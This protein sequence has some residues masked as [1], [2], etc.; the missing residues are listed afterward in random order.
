MGDCVICHRTDV[1]YSVEHVIPEALGGCYLRKQMVCVD[2]NSKLGRRVDAALI[3][4]GLSKMFRFVHG[5][6]G[7]AKKPPNPF[8]GEYR[9]R[10]D[11]GRRMKIRI[12]SG[13][14]LIPSLIPEVRR[15]ELPDGR[16]GVNISVD[17]TDER[18]LEPMVRTIANRLGASA[19]E[20]VANA[21][22]T[23]L[24]SDGGLAGQLALDLRDFKIGLLKIA[25]ECAVDRIPDYVESGDAQQIARI[26]REARF[27]EVE[28]YVNIGDGF[29]RGIMAPFSNFLGY[30]GVKHYLVLCGSVTGVRCFVHLHDLFSIGVTLSTESFGELFE[31]GVND[32]E[33][34]SFKVW[35][36]E[37]MQVSTGYCPLLHFETKRKAAEFR[38]AERAEDFAYESNDGRWKL[39]T[40]DG[41]YTGSDVG[42]VVRMLAPIRSEIVSGGLME[43][44]WLGEGVYL[45][46][47]GSGEIV[48]V[49][50]V[51]AEHVWQKL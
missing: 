32:V 13:G 29:D 16:V 33:G 19:E 43:E 46:L 4:H 12:G 51:R 22:K 41:R 47:S 28:R 50:A 48:R 17:S 36:V 1:R 11:P 40:R 9:L 44:F 21:K 45:R 8:A 26:L 7:K 35:R 2:C 15:D 14:R 34:R 39:F 30:E 20:A 5:L 6:R 18:K 23:V 31:I 24:S 25:Y 42:D 3:N 27:D 38:D 37:D 49:L 10:S